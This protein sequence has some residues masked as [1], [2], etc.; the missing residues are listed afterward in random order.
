MV[1]ISTIIGT[2]VDFRDNFQYK[3]NNNIVEI[4]F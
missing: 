2:K 1:L 3:V 4:N